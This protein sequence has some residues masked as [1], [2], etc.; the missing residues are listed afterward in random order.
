MMRHL[1]DLTG[2]KLP[3][4]EWFWGVVYT[5]RK[6]WVDKLVEVATAQRAKKPQSSYFASAK[7]LKLA[8]EWVAELLKHDYK[9]KGKCPEAPASDPVL[10]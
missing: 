1:P 6:H 3:P 10:F 7:T 8:P 5:L 2:E 4:R 9:P